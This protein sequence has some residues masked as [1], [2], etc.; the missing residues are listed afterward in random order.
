MLNLLKS[1]LKALF[2][3]KA[4]IYA[5]LAVFVLSGSSILLNI[6]YD[7]P[8]LGSFF[9]LAYVNMMII[10]V[11]IGL[12][13]YR[14]YSQNTIRNKI[15]VGHSRVSIFVA[16]TITILT[17]FVSTALVQTATA[18]IAGSLFGDLDYI[19]WAVFAQNWAVYFVT[20][21]VVTAM[22]SLIAVNIQSPIGAMLPMMLLFFIMFSGMIVLEMFM[23]DGNTAMI[24]LFQTTPILNLLT[25]VATEK[26]FDLLSTCVMGAAMFLTMELIGILIFKKL[27]LK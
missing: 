23:I 11:I 6:S 22:V 8:T 25:L 12:F 5:I 9:E 18:L 19:D 7:D 3:W 21:V 24:E 10:S 14:D 26:P 2:K 17:M 15:V 13:V 4:T 27:D 20:I 1:D 16:K